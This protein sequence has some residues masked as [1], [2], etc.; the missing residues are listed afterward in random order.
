MAK[1]FRKM[2]AVLL[3][4][5]V[6]SG[7][8]TAMPGTAFASDWGIETP[9]I[10][11][12][13]NESYVIFDGNG[14]A[15]E[16][17]RTVAE[18]SF[19]EDDMLNEILNNVGVFEREGFVL[20]GWATS[21]DGADVQEISSIRP[22]SG[23]TYYAIWSQYVKVTLMANGGYFGK[24]SVTKFETEAEYGKTLAKLPSTDPKSTQKGQVFEGWYY[25]SKCTKPLGGKLSQFSP[26]EDTVL[27]AGYKSDGT[28]VSKITLSKK[29]AAIL[30]GKSGTLTATAAPK[31]AL[32][33]EV[34]WKSSNKAIAT[35]SSKGVV[36]GIAPGTV[37]ITAT[38]K[39]GSGI[40]ATC[41]LTVSVKYVYECSKSGV[42]RYTTDTA[43][44]KKLRDAGWSYQKAFR[45]PG[46]SP[47]KV[48][49]VYNKTTKRYR[50]TNDL[51][52][53]KQMKA[54]GHKVGT[55]FYQSTARTVP[56]YELSKG[57][58]RVT[59]FY[60]TSAKVRKQMKA[61]GWKETGIAWYAQPK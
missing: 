6:L 21:P 55:A 36:K 26:T 44:V 47:Q 2:M 17:G 12:T 16:D 51:A 31:T 32:N 3:S 45:A 54:A 34:S 23:R 13:D 10:E 29:S 22:E 49:Y 11:I 48:Y 39:D 1:R 27:Y 8:L 28:M 35:V 24:T 5:A 15:L 30:V 61:E 25:D 56:V 7:S 40:K 20:T 33:K 19:S 60:T 14:G 52:Y 38:A 42:Y 9:E 4:A 43:V 59:C 58:K 57:S 18:I 46:L 37:T 50:Y 53:A 41:K